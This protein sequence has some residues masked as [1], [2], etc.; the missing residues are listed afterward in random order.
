MRALLRKAWRTVRNMPRIAREHSRLK[1]AVIA[2]VGI[3]LAL[4]L[5]ILFYAGFA[6]LGQQG[7]GGVMI[8]NSLFALFFFGLGLMLVFSSAVTS[9]S[10]TF[11][12]PETAFLITRP[13]PL[14]GV[15]LYKYLESVLLSSWA[16]FF[17][18]V[19]FLAAFAIYQHLSFGFAAGMLLY[20]V[21]FVMI[22]CAVGMVIMFL[23]ARIL[24][25]GRWLVA[26][27]VVLL[28]ASATALGRAMMEMPRGQDDTTLVLGKLI[29]GVRISSHPLWPS[30]WM[31]EGLLSLSRDDWSRALWLL[32]LTIAN[33]AMGCVVVEWM[34]RT[35]FDAIWHRLAPSGAR[36][37][38]STGGQSVLW[39]VLAPF[40]QA[41]RAIL[42][43]DIR[44]F[45]RD[46]VQ[47]TQMLV[48]FG[49][50]ALY[51][52]N[53]RHFHYEAQAEE[54]R[55]IIAFLNIVSVSAV[56][57]SLSS[58]FLYPQMSLEGHS[59]WILGM[60]PLPL[61]RVLRAKFALSFT[62]L[63]IIGI[64][65][66]LLSTSMLALDLRMRLVAVLLAVCVAAAVSGLAT[67]LGAIFMDLRNRNP[68]AIVSGFGGTLNLVLG[69]GFIFLA[70][71]PFAALFH[72]E[73]THIIPGFNLW[74]ALLVLY[75]VVLTF[76]TAGIPLIL[77][78]RSLE[79]REY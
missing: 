37:R 44:F 74:A 68:I 55:V 77:G 12:S 62:V 28:A 78:G 54:W 23:L 73:V 71:L 43:K 2:S 1:M 7:G 48:F 15:V 47:W 30:W 45:L 72:F 63:G 34:G 64:T 3:G 19:P 13:I 50:L 66:A 9:Y 4:G 18:V 70:T 69:L 60:S 39:R 17:I 22:C 26:L 6:F 33:A 11:R 20:A 42:I 67:G 59:F 40:D 56:M 31:A 29:P 41:T 53:L 32:L 51:F 25:R 52:V 27:G 14:G 21:P 10:V 5:G 65:L 76:L 38:A 8:L 75:V 58:R 16:F 79:R 36:R 46:P 61:R 24:P 35:N 49:L 57:C